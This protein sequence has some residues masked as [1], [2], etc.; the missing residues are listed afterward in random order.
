MNI[1]LAL[2]D[3]IVTLFVIL[4]PL[5]TLPFFLSLT[6][7]A[8]DRQ[9]KM[10]ATS[11]VSVA[12]V[13]LVVF[14]YM[15]YFIM[16]L[17]GIDIFDFEIAGG[18]LLLVFSIRDALSSEPLRVN[19]YESD[20][21]ESALKS[22]AIIPIATPLLA[23]PGSLTTVMLLAE[24]HFGLLV[25]GIAILVDC[26]IALLVLRSGS[27]LNRIIGTSGLMIF[28]KVMDIIMAAIAVSFL[29]RG[30]AGIGL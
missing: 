19:V 1:F 2:I 9:R 13:M 11:A 21:I 5:G 12:F 27:A 23:G 3:G 4:D 28:G 24:T 17:L 16:A 30:I 29:V 26:A 14:A 10:V 8:D 6:V 18:L 15:G 25:S 20:K 7:N 22:V